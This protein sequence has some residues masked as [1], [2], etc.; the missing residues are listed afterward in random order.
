MHLQLLLDCRMDGA[1][2]ISVWLTLFLGCVLFLLLEPRLTAAKKNGCWAFRNA[3]EH[4]AIQSTITA[5]GSR[6]VLMSIIAAV[7]AHQLSSTKGSLNMHNRGINWAFLSS[8][9]SKVYGLSPLSWN[10]DHTKQQQGCLQGF[11]HG[12]YDGRPEAAEVPLPQGL[13]QGLIDEGPEAAD[14]PVVPKPHFDGKQE[15]RNLGQQQS[16]QQFHPQCPLADAVATADVPEE[17][18][19]SSTTIS[20]R[21]CSIPGYVK[22][23]MMRTKLDAFGLRGAY[24]YFF[25]PIDPGTKQS[26]GEAFINLV[27]P[28]FISKLRASLAEPPL[29][30]VLYSGPTVQ[31]Q[32]PSPQV[33]QGFEQKANDG[34]TMV[35]FDTADATGEFHFHKTKL[36]VFYAKNRCLLGTS[37]HFAHSYEE[38][39]APPDLIK[40]RPCYNFYRN[41]C[42]DTQCRYA[43]GHHELR[44][45]EVAEKDET[46]KAT[47]LTTMEREQFQ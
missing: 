41:K 25:M 10:V 16:V 34:H 22:P 19:P 6:Q 39:Q 24:D 33:G 4:L 32:K 3:P 9:G 43:H 15:P 11:V 12:D 7:G 44:R 23:V 20:L 46:R 45:K 2:E 30:G 5:T 35:H 17:G 8:L 26:K 37:C 42:V 27:H 21:I 28:V 38:L 18:L 40:T 29:W 47:S 36:C 14:G 1:L 31:T 13:L